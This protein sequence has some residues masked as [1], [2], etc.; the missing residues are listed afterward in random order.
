MPSRVLD[1]NNLGM[2]EDWVGNN[3][4]FTCPHCSKVF[5]VSG[6]RIH[7]GDKTRS[8]SRECP[9]CGKS[10]GHCTIKGQP[11]GGSASLEW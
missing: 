2:D 4:A 1:Q 9:N 6:T 8:S 3:A 5:I 10:K 11:S 7:G